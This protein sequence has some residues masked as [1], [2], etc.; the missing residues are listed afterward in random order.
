VL[1]LVEIAFL[2]SRICVPLKIPDI[3]VTASP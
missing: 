3:A 2:R 1:G